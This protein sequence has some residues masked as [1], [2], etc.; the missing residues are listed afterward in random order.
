MEPSAAQRVLEALGGELPTLTD[1]V[2]EHLLTGVELGVR[3]HDP[4]EVWDEDA[5]TIAF[6]LDGITYVAVEDPSDG[7]RSSMKKLELGDPGLVKNTFAPIHVT[8][9]FGP[10]GGRD[11]EDRDEVLEFREVSTGALILEV[12]TDNADDYYP[13]F[14]G[15]WRPERIGQPEGESK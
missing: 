13:S 14:V 6:I 2:G 4:G 5:N 8:A 9:A 15:N 7:Y 12:G 10:S 1:L 11:Y 3:K